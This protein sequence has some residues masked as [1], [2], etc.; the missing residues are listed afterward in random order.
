MQVLYLAHRVPFPPNKGDKIRAFHEI[1]ALAARHHDIHLFAFADDPADLHH[2]AELA[3]FCASVTILPLTRVAGA[4]R[5]LQALF[6]T[7]SLSV[8]YYNSAPMHA[9]VRNCVQQVRPEAAVVYSSTMAQYVPLSLRPRTVVDLVDVDSAKWRDYATR[10]PFP[11]STVYALEA[12]RLQAY[13]RR[14][15]SEFPHIVLT[16]SR[17]VELLTSS[18]ATGHVHAL[19]N[20]V[21]TRHFEPAPLPRQGPKEIVFTGAMDYF[22]NID[23][24]Q[25]FADEVWPGL[26]GT[27]DLRFTIVGSRPAKSVRALAQRDG[28]DVTGTVPDV[29]PYLHRATVVVVPLR[30]ARGVQNKLLEAM[31]AG[32]PVVAT[33]P[34]V[35]AFEDPKTLPVRVA[36]TPAEFAQATAELLADDDARTSLGRAAREYVE[37]HHDWEPMLDQFC[38]LVETCGGT[39]RYA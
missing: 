15:L 36:S 11:A 38:S 18:A 33:P 24:A 21:D 37:R 19:M 13:E 29:R 3:R 9:A 25:W 30:I 6:S 8:A 26:R 39:A 7:A 5:A 20:G 10:R 22:P 35:A 31:A 2:H 32:V 12:D 14:L 28:I 4:A 34:A 17:E 23:G 16:T 1:R 27:T